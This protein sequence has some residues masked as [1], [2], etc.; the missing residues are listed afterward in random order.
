MTDN[1]FDSVASF[2]SG[3]ITADLWT[4]A[5]AY[6]MSVENVT[7]NGPVT[8]SPPVI[9]TPPQSQTVNAGATVS[10]TVAATVLR[11]SAILW[12]KNGTNLA[13]G[14][15]VSGASTTNLTLTN[16]STA[17]SGAYA[18]TVSN[19]GGG[20]TSA[21][22]TLTVIGPPVI[23]TQPASR[24]NNDRN[25]RQLCGERDRTLLSYQWRFNGTNIA[26]AIA[27]SYSRTNVQ[28]ADAGSYT[29]LVTNSAG[30]VTSSAAILTVI[31]ATPPSITTQPQSQ[32][33]IAGQSASFSV[34]ATGTAPLSYQWRFNGTNI[35]GAT[36]T[37]YTKANVQATNAGNYS[38]VATNSAG[39]AT[40]YGGGIDGDRAGAAGHHGAAAGPDGDCGPGCSFFRRR[41]GNRA[42]DLSMEI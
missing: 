31:T 12:T 32:T 16:V 10:F 17:D 42:V 6:A 30:S 41:D 35:A 27:A 39:S 5:N 26:G 18:V 11:H 23:V 4:D 20:V 28:A 21:S 25:D 29:V 40:M 3:G 37:N 2:A 34:A 19:A 1:N 33:V 15:N 7:V 36:A 9:S 13:N 22:A 14:G 24:T 8:V 38:V